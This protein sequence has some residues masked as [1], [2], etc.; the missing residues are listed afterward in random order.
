MTMSKSLQ[1][2]RHHEKDEFFNVFNELRAKKSNLLSLFDLRDN[3]LINVGVQA[4]APSKDYCQLIL[5]YHYIILRR[6][7][8]SLRGDSETRYPTEIKDTYEDFAH[9]ENIERNTHFIYLN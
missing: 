2:N 4:K 6:W 5:N 3:E 7:K 9:D 8:I 1:D